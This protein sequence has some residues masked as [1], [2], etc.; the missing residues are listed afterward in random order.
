P[1]GATLVYFSA[2]GVV[3]GS[4]PIAEPY[5]MQ[6][7]QTLAPG[8]SVSV[9]AVMDFSI[10]AGGIAP[11]TY[12][13]FAVLI[14]HGALVGGAILALDLPSFTAR[15]P[16]APAPSVSGRW[17]ISQL[18][19]II[20]IHLHLLPTGKVLMWPGDHAPEE[21]SM[22]WDPATG[23][24]SYTAAIA[25][26]DVFCSGHAFLPDGSLL[27]AG[28]SMDSA[29]ITGALDAAV[30]DPFQNAW[31][32]VPQM[33]AGRWYPTNTTLP[34]GDV[35]GAAGTIDILIGSNPQPLVHQ[36]HT[37]EWRP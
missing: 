23:Q 15:A 19:P 11:G 32:P 18:L 22:L 10:P 12:Q 9:P 31:R 28:G 21:N 35:L 26:F 8:A 6:P 30:Y 2:P 24:A 25:G 14:P 33:N 4:V 13:F 17:T 20:P 3:G 16:A 36:T 5:A 1:D 37:G 29:S 34:S 27:V 7:M